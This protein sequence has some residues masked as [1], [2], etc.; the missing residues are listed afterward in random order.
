VT[1]GVAR[2]FAALRAEYWTRGAAGRAT[3]EPVV[4]GLYRLWLVALTLKVLGSS[5]DVAWHF[6]WL[7]D[8]FAP[9]HLVN[10]VGTVLAVALVVCHGYTGYGVDERALR[11]MQWGTGIFLVAIPLDGST[12]GSTAWTSPR[13]APR[14]RCCTWAPR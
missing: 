6:R 7:R 10:S 11:L 14:T 4:V 9:P 1:T 13:G 12:T 5:W 2:R 3:P 8:D